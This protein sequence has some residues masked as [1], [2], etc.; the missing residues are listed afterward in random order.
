VE[1]CREQPENLSLPSRL[2]NNF[3]SVAQYQT[4]TAWTGPPRLPEIPAAPTVTKKEGAYLWIDAAVWVWP[5]LEKT[6]TD[7][8]YTVILTHAV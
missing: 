7:K 1:S 8:N 4:H 3:A 5:L 2:E 6:L